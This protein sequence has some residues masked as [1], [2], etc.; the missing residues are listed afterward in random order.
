MK[1]NGCLRCEHGLPSM[2]SACRA[3]GQ[4]S[5]V[6]GQPRRFRYVRKRERQQLGTVKAKEG[7][8]LRAVSMEPCDR[9][10]PRGLAQEALVECWA[11]LGSGI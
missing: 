8:V 10:L 4:G 5:G 9:L 6:K 1:Y 3:W 11:S 7:L 2:S